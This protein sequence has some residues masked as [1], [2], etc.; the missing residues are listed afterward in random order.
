VRGGRKNDPILKLPRFKNNSVPSKKKE[1]F[2]E[3]RSGR[4]KKYPP[5]KTAKSEHNKRERIEIKKFIEVSCERTTALV[6][7]NLEK[8]K[9]TRKT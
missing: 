1:S 2:V 6:G 9:K 4:K 5:A 7:K 8:K 3:A